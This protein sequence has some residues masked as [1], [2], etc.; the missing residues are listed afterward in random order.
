MAPNKIKENVKCILDKFSFCSLKIEIRYKSFLTGFNF[1]SAFLPFFLYF[2]IDSI[3]KF[4]SVKH[5]QAI[6]M[7]NNASF[8]ILSILKKKQ[9]KKEYFFSLSQLLF[10]LYHLFHLLSHS[11]ILDLF[12]CFSFFHFVLPILCM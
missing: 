10:F 6:T 2:I 8:P 3:K 7:Y 11:T 5:I 4:L 12:L 1:F 9:K